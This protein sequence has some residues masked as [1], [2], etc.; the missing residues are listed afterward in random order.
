MLN[1]DNANAD[2]TKILLKIPVD[3]VSVKVSVLVYEH[4]TNGAQFYLGTDD[5][6]IVG[7]PATPVLRL[8]NE[9]VISVETDLSNNHLLDLS[10]CVLRL[11]LDGENGGEK[12]KKYSCIL[13]TIFEISN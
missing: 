3:K 4:L 5:L 6:S 2:E 1:K 7:K 10:G 9:G 8:N 13:T 11:L 12:L